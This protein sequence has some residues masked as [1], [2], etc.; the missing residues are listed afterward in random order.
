M[1]QQR[2][3]KSILAVTVGL[4]LAGTL[5]PWS[6]AVAANNDG[7]VVGKVVIAGGASANDV[8]LVIRNRET[9]LTRTVTAAADGSFRFP[10]LPVG[11][12]SVSA[13]KTGFNAV[14]LDN[15]RVGLGT[16]T[17]VNLTLDSGNV[18]TVTV[19]GNRVI[20]S[21][22][23]SSSE[24]GLNISSRELER[25]PVSRDVSSVALLAPGVN[26]GSERMRS[27]LSFGGSSVAENAIYI[28]G[29]NVTDIYR[30]IGFSSVPYSFY[31]EFQVK[32]GGYSVEFG[33]STGGVINAVTKTGTNDFEF[34]A[35][36]YWQPDRLR[37]NG[38]DR[39]DID[40]QRYNAVSR[41]T[42]DRLNLNISASGPIIED[43]LFF[44]ALYEARDYQSDS[45]S[46][47]DSRV[48]RYEEPD[49]FW[50]VKLDW[51]INDNHLLE[52]LGFS[53]SSDTQSDVYAYNWAND[54]IGTPVGSNFTKGGG[55][56]WALTYT[57]YLTDDLSMK[58]L[59]GENN[60]ADS[61]FS[62][63]DLICD[64]Y[65]DSRT[66]QNGRQLGCA[67]RT[68][69]EDQENQREAMRIDFEWQ[70]G[71]H[72]LRFGMDNEL[73]TTDY[74][75][76]Y[77]GSGIRYQAL[78]RTPGTRLPNGGIVPAGVNEVVYARR[79][80]I[81]GNF[82]TET[83]AL[84]VED[85]WTVTDTLTINGG[86]RVD[87]FDNRDQEGRTYIEQDNQIG[88]RIGLA[89]DV[90]GDG[91]SKVFANAG[92]YYLPV[93]NVINVKQAGGLLDERTYWVMLGNTPYEFN[94]QTFYRP[95]LGAQ[96]GPM[97][98]SQGDG[99]VGD[100]R[101]E[102][103]RDLDPVYQDELIVGYESM[104]DDRWSW[105]VRGIYRNTPNAIDDI[106]LTGNGRCGEDGYQGWVMA[107]PGSVV[108]V[109][110]DS[111]CDGENDSYISIDTAKE[112]WV[113]PDGSERGWVKPKR[114]YK[115]LEF[116]LDRSWDA[117][118]SMNAS[119]TLAKSEG[120]VEGPVNSDTGF[121][122]SGRT[123]AFDDPWVNYGSGRLPN[124]IRHQFKL[125]GAYALTDDLSMGLNM[126]ANSGRPISAQGVGNPYDSTNYHSWFICVADCTTD[127]PQYQLTKRGQ[128][129]ET[130]WV[131][132][133]DF[134]VS[135]DMSL[136]GT[137]MKLRLDI[138]NVLNSQ[139][140]LLVDE[141][142]D[143]D[144]GTTNPEFLRASAW[145]S[146]RYM[147]ISAQVKF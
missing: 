120:N 100:L 67:T 57:G 147:Q 66:G 116:Q 60:R 3:R 54:R 86:I 34:G 22:D 49:D 68:L 125:R 79:Y 134:N 82:E 63:S 112:G 90:N 106:E 18:E 131:F 62:S 46:D 19:M 83:S 95:Q 119:Y 61:S 92:R 114:V 121:S 85:T 146:P 39:F 78:T 58:V 74:D 42:A 28:N 16:A 111:D 43:K 135:Y 14:K 8:T 33:R 65:T 4:C 91:E 122:D 133:I 2:F 32:T 70:L 137:D 30:R 128:Y 94:G 21:V 11:E 7:A 107:N 144:I 105:G 6:A 87:N 53:D 69:V 64:F 55:D 84:Y 17:T 80:A 44:F 77:V 93:A 12:Y 72:L 129:G 27:G 15:I 71:A 89:W 110:G 139:S 115:A 13:E 132:N 97:D 35:E 81:T 73:N 47:S 127:T 29:L 36:A 37:G 45:Y 20:T 25:M 41:D 126:R 10:F 118:W 50:G 108:T 5:A 51:Q 99:T 143:L 124:D 138:F 142:R 75:Q 31:K 96:I 109:W 102:V 98:N 23:A 48:S 136:G 140:V 56:N 113:M 130:P 103:D 88:P 145:Q 52:L 123:E 76:H 40:G 38:I 101:A 141:E 104:I 117:K 9:G 1:K 24:S 26:A 59:Y